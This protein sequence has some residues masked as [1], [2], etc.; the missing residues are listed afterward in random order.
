MPKFRTPRCE[1][2]TESGG[3]CGHDM[4][5]LGERDPSFGPNWQPGHWVFLCPYCGAVRAIDSRDAGRY[6]EAY[7]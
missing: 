5:A 7:R 6:T 1:A 4:R 3:R 2:P